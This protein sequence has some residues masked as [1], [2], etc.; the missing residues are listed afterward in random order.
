MSDEMLVAN[1]AT[2]VRSRDMFMLIALWMELFPQPK[3]KT[4][5]GVRP[6]GCVLVDSRDRILSL[7]CTG[8]S[9]SIV[10]AI[11]SSPVDPIGCDMCT[12]MMVQAGIR[13]IYYFPAKEW[14]MD[15]DNYCLSQEKFE[16][17]D[18][19]IDQQSLKFRIQEKKDSNLQSVQ[20]LVSNNPIAMTRFIPTWSETYTFISPSTS[21]VAGGFP[22]DPLWELDDSI[23]NTPQL[24][25]QY[26]ALAANFDKTVQALAYLK[27][28]YQKIPK[29]ISKDIPLENVAIYQHAIV[30]AH[31]AAKRTDDPKVGVG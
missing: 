20:R 31:I 30:L 8:E 24:F 14:E 29:H 26:P 17:P 22:D 10:K 4:L 27:R 16:S 21:P 15:W 12:K 6:S 3:A 28:K 7:Q 9:H 13:K 5:Y 23:A 11:L 1:N 19:E 2:R 25:K 18:S